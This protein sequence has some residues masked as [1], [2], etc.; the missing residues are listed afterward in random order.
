MQSIA[1][2]Y[3]HQGILAR[4]LFTIFPWEILKFFQMIQ[5]LNQSYKR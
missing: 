3:E 2:Y 1:L 5:Y 4:I